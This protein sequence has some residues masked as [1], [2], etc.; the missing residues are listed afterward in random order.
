MLTSPLPLTPPTLP[1]PPAWIVLQPEMQRIEI[2]IIN[3]NCFLFTRTPLCIA[4]G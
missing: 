3:I 2:N 4:S 1:L